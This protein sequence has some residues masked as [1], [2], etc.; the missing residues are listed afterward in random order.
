VPKH[1]A[2]G[3]VGHRD[4]GETRRHLV[5]ADAVV[6]PL[7]DNGMRPVLDSR[8]AGNARLDG[9]RLSDHGGCQDNG[10]LGAKLHDRM[11]SS[12]RRAEGAQQVGVESYT[13]LSSVEPAR[14]DL[15]SQLDLGLPRFGLGN[16]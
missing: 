16:N 12:T 13:T 4:L 14:D 8:L 7:H 9:P 11:S 10:N 15:A 1:I 6:D 2:G 3:P 5:D